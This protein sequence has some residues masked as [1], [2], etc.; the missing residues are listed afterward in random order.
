MLLPAAVTDVLHPALRPLRP[1]VRRQW[2]NEATIDA[3]TSLLHPT[4]RLNR[5]FARVVSRKW[6]AP[7]M[8]A[9]GLKPNRNW[10]G[11]QPGQHVQVTVEEG[12]VRHSRS[13]SLTGLPGARTLEIG[14][15][16]TAGGRVSNLLLDGVSLGHVVEIGPAF[17]ELQ[18]P[19]PRDPGLVLLAGGSG[20]TPLLGLLRATLAADWRKPVLLL[21]YVR[22]RALQPYG[23]E[24][25]ALAKLHPNLRVGVIETG[26]TE[27]SM[28]ATAPHADQLE[29]W[30]A[31]LDLAPGSC[32]VRACGPAAFVACVERWWEAGGHAGTLQVE[33][34]TPPV[35]RSRSQVQAV[36]LQL[37]RSQAGYTLDN[38]RPLLE[39]ME[40]RGLRPAHGCRIGI[41]HT[42]TCRKKSGAVQDLR[43]G[44]I[45]RAPDELIRLCVSAP[46]SDVVLDL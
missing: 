27:A 3:W 24:L 8:L 31:D 6:V 2:L 19:R 44:E 18:P 29:G 30:L 13:Y 11:F 15:K 39:Q 10:R 5:V 28:A 7:D 16:R 12:G 26:D 23:D 9:L 40:A 17:G 41:C 45:H 1:L 20:I 33:A 34:F 35:L 21:Q 42:C 32:A 37:H 46:V 22:D 36:Q 25:I 14:I 43:T 4:W 38:Q